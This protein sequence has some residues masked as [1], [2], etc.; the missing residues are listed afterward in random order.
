MAMYLVALV[1]GAGAAGYAAVPLYRLFCQ[2]TG[3]GGTTRESKGVG[4]LAREQGKLDAEKLRPIL[5]EFQGNTSR[6]MPWEFTPEQESVTVVPGESALAFYRAKNTT[7]QTITGVA[8]YNVT[9]Q[10]AGIYFNKIQCFCFEEQRLEPGE[11]VDMP[12]FFFIDPEILN[13][14]RMKDISYI[15]L[16]YTFFRT[17]EDVQY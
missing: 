7:D 3:F 16:S 17:S 5:I 10:K 13:D 6:Q 2:A 11:E 14:P 15:T 8:T 9:P 4:I 1:L 12:V